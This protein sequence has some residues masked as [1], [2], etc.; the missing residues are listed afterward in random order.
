MPFV[1]EGEGWNFH[2]GDDGASLLSGQ[3]RKQKRIELPFVCLLRAAGWGRSLLDLT[4]C[5]TQENFRA[6]NSTWAH[7]A[8][9]RMESTEEF[10]GH[11][12]NASLF[13]LGLWWCQRWWHT[14]MKT[15][16]WLP[17]EMSWISGLMLLVPVPVH[18]GNW[19]KE[20]TFYHIPNMSQ[21]LVDVFHS[22]KCAFPLSLITAHH[23]ANYHTR[24]PPSSF[25][26]ELPFLLIGLLHCPWGL[27]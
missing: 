22:A 20:V 5:G 26:E 2:I 23:K 25:S 14:A 10:S 24:L 13:A 21:S 18:C 4:G 19:K 27:P 3:W 6:A 9:G 16:S 11:I 1:F 12:L 17:Q 15:L 7:F 8:T